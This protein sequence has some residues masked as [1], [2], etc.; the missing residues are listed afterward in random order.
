MK[1]SSFLKITCIVLIFCVMTAIASSAQTLTTLYGFGRYRANGTIPSTLLVQGFD[2]NF[3]GTTQSGGT[4]ANCIGGC[5]TV[6]K[7]TNTGKLTSLHSFDETDGM[8]PVG[9]L[10]QVTNEDFYGATYLGDTVFQITPAGALTTLYRFC[11]QV[12]CPT[13]ENPNGVVL[14]ANGNLYGTT[15]SGWHTND[16]TQLLRSNGMR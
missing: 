3:Y 15:H 13:G 5:G 4:G 1:K 14:G 7:L 8:D 16:A 2:G 6:F 10:V 12:G 11:A 9:P